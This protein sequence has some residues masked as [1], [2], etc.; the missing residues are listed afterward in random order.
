MYQNKLNQQ[1]VYEIHH[2]G[3]SLREL[4]VIAIVIGVILTLLSPYV[5]SMRESARQLNCQN[6]LKQLGLAMHHYEKVHSVFPPAAIWE[7]DRM[8]S[9]ALHASK[10]TDLFI[11]S[12]WVQMLLPYLDYEELAQQFNVNQPVAHESNRNYRTTP[13]PI[14]SCPSDTYNVADNNF[15]FSPE[16]DLF[17]QFA[18]G[19]Y[20]INGGTHC[21]K[22]DMG[23]TS[24]LAGDAAHILVDQD[25]RT[26]Q[27]WGN[28]IAGFN[29]SFSIDD[30]QNGLSTLVALEEVRAGIHPLD[31]RGA[32]AWGHIASSV[33]WAHGVNGDDYGPNNQ[34]PRSDD[35]AGCGQLHDLIGTETLLREKMPC[36]SYVDI[37]QNAT[38]RSLHKD[39][40]NVLFLDGAVRFIHDNIDP[41]LWHVIHSRETPKQVL[42]NDFEEKLNVVNH[43]QDAQK[44]KSYSQNGKETSSAPHNFQNSIGMEF[45]LIPKGEYEMGLPDNGNDY[46]LPKESPKHRVIIPQ[47]FYLSCY[48]VTQEQYASVMKH[49]PSFHSSDENTKQY[50]VEQVTWFDAQEYCEQLSQLASENKS[51]RRY[52]LPTEAEWEYA[53]RSGSTQ[54]YYYTGTRLKA[55]KTGETAGIQPPLP[56]AQVGRYLPNSFG[57]YD[58]RGNAWEWCSDWFDRDYYSRSPQIDPQ[59]PEH[60]YI[61]VVRGSDWTYIGEGCKI[62]Y[63]MLPPWKSSPF[64]SFRVVCETT[65]K[66]T[67]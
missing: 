24:S 21:F 5:L 22:T 41:G 16:N 47:S 40:V 19:N 18:R 26:F 61:K 58:M 49:N 34:G 35:F 50:P 46:N 20:S 31:P 30:F 6:N 38:A 2:S 65:Q 64:V 55:D 53:C 12:N 29:K 25:S 48:E 33:T 59:G 7:T 1:S 66:P 36:V 10:R 15:I 51:G 17:I 3:F 54:P 13:L 4:F 57:L 32:W 45:V 56:L 23:T 42:A 60:G 39:G 28:G 14:M 52:R 44:S 43:L 8:H 62:N 63:P 27:Y 11:N 67:Q 9:L 37:N